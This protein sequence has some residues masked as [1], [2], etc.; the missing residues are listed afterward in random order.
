MFEISQFSFI[1]TTSGPIH[2]DIRYKDNAGFNK[3]YLNEFFRAIN[4]NKKSTELII[5]NEHTGITFDIFMEK[6][7]I[8]SN[9]TTIELPLMRVDISRKI[10]LQPHVINLTLSCINNFFG[11]DYSKG[12]NLK[13]IEI[14]FNYDDCEYIDRTYV[15][16]NLINLFRNN[17][18]NLTHLY[19][20]E[21]I[22]FSKYEKCKNIIN[23]I[24]ESVKLPYGCKVV[25]LDD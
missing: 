11:I 2:L 17:S 13:I 7:K 14:I 8:P 24:M 15:N 5:S 16:G 6:F 10:K 1:E 3:Q 20:L 18:V 19:Q 12:A 21:Q 23:T 22:G 4:R 9:I 25:F